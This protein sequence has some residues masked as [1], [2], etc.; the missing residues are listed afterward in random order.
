MDHP[1]SLAG[2]YAGTALTGTA[3]GAV[4][5]VGEFRLG[6]PGGAGRGRAGRGRAVSAGESW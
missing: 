5:A 3:V 6:G 2:A 1:G 4:G